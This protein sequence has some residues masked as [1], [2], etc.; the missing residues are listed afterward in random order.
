M[1][2]K[3]V[4]PEVSIYR[5]AMETAIAGPVVSIQTTEWATDEIVGD[6]AGEGGDI[7]IAW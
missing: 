4:N 2:K 5:V 3:Y 1:Q 6:D 7:Y